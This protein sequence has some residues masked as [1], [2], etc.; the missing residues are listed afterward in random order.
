MKVKTSLDMEHADGRHL[1]HVAS[2]SHAHALNSHGN[3][4]Q[5]E[6]RRALTTSIHPESDWRKKC[7]Q[8]RSLEQQ[9]GGSF[10]AEHDDDSELYGN[11]ATRAKT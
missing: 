3:Q 6:R 1:Q 10:E 4:T 9:L 5:H 7:N 11:C 8:T 2:N